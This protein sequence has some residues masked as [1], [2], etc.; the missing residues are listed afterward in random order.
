MLD[1]SDREEKDTP[2]IAELK[3]RLREEDYPMFTNQELQYF[4]D[5]SE[6]LDMATYRAAI[7]KSEADGLTLNGITLNSTADFF[8]RIASMYRPINSGILKGV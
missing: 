4:I 7:F 1:C 6:S 2:E 5:T 8:L 3:L